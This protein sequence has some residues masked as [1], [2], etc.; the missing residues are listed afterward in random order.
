M[1]MKDGNLMG[2]RG[3]LWL[4]YSEGQYISRMLLMSTQDFKQLIVDSDMRGVL[5]THS[6]RF[7]TLAA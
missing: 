3:D 4:Y 5:K 1:D 7:M 6:L 2:T